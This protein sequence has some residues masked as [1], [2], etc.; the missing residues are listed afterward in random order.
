MAANWELEAFAYSVSHDL[1][2]PLR[3]IDG[4]L[5]LLQKK[6]GTALDEH[7]RHYMDAISEAAKKMGLLIDDL[8]SFSRMG[9]MP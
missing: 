9:D 2:A 6:A 4:F 8:L 1:R 5:E 7:S 3:H